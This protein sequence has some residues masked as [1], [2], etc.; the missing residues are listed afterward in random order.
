[1]EGS[2]AFASIGGGAHTISGDRIPTLDGV[3]PLYGSISRRR[4]A[5]AEAEVLLPMKRRYLRI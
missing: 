1:V 3:P 4:T 2:R 5:L